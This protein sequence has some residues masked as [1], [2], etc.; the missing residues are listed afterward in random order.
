MD[1]NLDSAIRN[2]ERAVENLRNTAQHMD[3]PRFCGM[4]GE[5]V[6]HGEIHVYMVATGECVR[7][8]VHTAATAQV[9]E[10]PVPTGAGRPPTGPWTGPEA[11]R[12]A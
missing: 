2:V 3:G 12:F 7:A 9:G 1:Y 5:K 4:C 10:L 11:R 6:E 8:Q